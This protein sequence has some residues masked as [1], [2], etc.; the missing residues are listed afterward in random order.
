ME[1]NLLL[2]DATYFDGVN[3]ELKHSDI[4]VH[5]GK[6]VEIGENLTPKNSTEYQILDL[7]N[8]FLMPGLIDNHFHAYGISLSLFEIENTSMSYIALMAQKRLSAALQRGF[9]TVRDVAGGDYGLQ[10]A[11]KQG[12]FAAPDYYYAGPAISQTGGH[13]DP[14]NQEMDVCGHNHASGI[15]ADGVDQ[16]LQAART[17]LRKGAHLLKIMVSGGVVSLTDPIGIPQYSNAEIETVT[18]EAKRRGTY[19]TAHAYS[20]SAIIHAV[21]N[22]VGC[23]EHG[24]LMDEESANVMKAAGAHLVPTLITYEMMGKYGKEKGMPPVSIEKNSIVLQ[25]G[26][27]AIEL[28]SKKGIK[29]GF[30]T[31]LMG[32]L[33]FAQLDGVKSQWEVQGTLEAMRSL[34]SRNA[35]ILGVSQIGEIKEEFA[36]NFLVLSKNPFETPEVLWNQNLERTVIKNG[37]VY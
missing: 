27:N 2:K 36:G 30:G 4:L 3:E 21:K 24:N 16:V 12:L 1:N 8:K 20:A 7:K 11:I 28:A 31:D 37:V 13:A 14:R 32:E 6:I 17:N 35:E 26:R 18:S 10:K 25:A 33:E 23:I 5:S 19:V 9:T 29:I 22:G 15:I 34:T